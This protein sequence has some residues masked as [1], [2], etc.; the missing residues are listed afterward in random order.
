[1]NTITLVAWIFIYFIVLLFSYIFIVKRLKHLNQR[2]INYTK[3]EWLQW[4]YKSLKKVI[5]VL[6]LILFVLS[7]FIVLKFAYV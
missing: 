5:F 1:M 7:I 6:F 4:I 2:H 3:V